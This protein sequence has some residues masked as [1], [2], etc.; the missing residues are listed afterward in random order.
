[1]IKLAKK[2]K[3]LWFVIKM[4]TVAFKPSLL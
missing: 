1:M 3:I 4:N 2:H